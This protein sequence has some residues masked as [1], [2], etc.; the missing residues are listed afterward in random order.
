MN[1]QPTFGKP[2][3]RQSHNIQPNAEFN[4]KTYA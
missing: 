2:P 3:A 4:E 1:A